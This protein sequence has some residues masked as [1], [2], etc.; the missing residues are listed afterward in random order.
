ML[1]PELD[2]ELRYR[3]RSNMQLLSEQSEMIH[4]LRNEL[5]DCLAKKSDPNRYVRVK[6]ILDVL[7]EATR[8]NDHLIREMKRDISEYYGELLVR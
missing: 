7:T 1:S 6:E 4:E 2:R 5:N 8:N 3:I